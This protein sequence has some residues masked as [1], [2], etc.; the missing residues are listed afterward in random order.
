MMITTWVRRTAAFSGAIAVLCIGTGAGL[1]PAGASVTS[2]GST[3]QTRPAEQAA[4]TGQATKPAESAVPAESTPT[5]LDAV[6]CAKRDNA[7]EANADPANTDS[8]VT[9]DE[10][11][12]ADSPVTVDEKVRETATE[13]RT[14]APT[15]SAATTKCE[16]PLK[17]K[18][19]EKVQIKPFN[20]CYLK[21][22][23]GTV[24]SYFGYDL[25]GENA[26]LPAGSAYNY[27]D[28]TSSHNMGQPSSFQT[29]LHH[30]VFSVTWNSAAAK[31]LWTLN[32]STVSAT[33]AG[34]A[35]REEPAVPEFPFAVVG[36]LVVVAAFG[37]WFILR[38]RRDGAV[39]SIV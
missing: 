21:R 3:S 8:Q 22:D 9:V 17:P 24:T 30:L 20:E 28:A 5:E 12:A 11:V 13:K 27:F 16:E 29:G 37:G 15:R 25:A 18:H 36:P 7:V 1:V 35:C 34:K 23:D 19:T 26:S 10:K 33:D 31:P 32:G 39:E 14:I 4:Q 38:R 6:T 2:T